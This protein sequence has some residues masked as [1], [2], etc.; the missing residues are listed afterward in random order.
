MRWG[1]DAGCGKDGFVNVKSCGETGVYLIRDRRRRVR[2]RSDAP[3][4]FTIRSPFP[5]KAGNPSKE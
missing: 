1:E 4:Q 2:R 5:K 3:H